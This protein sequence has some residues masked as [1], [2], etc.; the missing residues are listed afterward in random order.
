MNELQASTTIMENVFLLIAVLIPL[1][2][3]LV[4]MSLKN[5]PNLREFTSFCAAVL[6][7]AVVCSFIPALKQA[8]PWFTRSS[9]CCQ[10]YPSP[11]VQMDFP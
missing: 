1:V 6:L 8:T 11:C 3:S 5:N 10:V 2:G 4:V 7:F 9:T